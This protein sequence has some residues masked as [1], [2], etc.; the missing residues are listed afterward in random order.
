MFDNDISSLAIQYK[1][2]LTDPSSANYDTKVN[3]VGSNINGKINSDYV[4]TS[5]LINT[6]TGLFIEDVY[7]EFSVAGV[8]APA[9]LVSDQP[10]IR[11]N[12]FNNDF[13]GSDIDYFSSIKNDIRS[14]VL[15]D[16]GSNIG[17]DFNG[18]HN[19]TR[20]LGVV[21][22]IHPLQNDEEDIQSRI[23]PIKENN[24]IYNQN[25]NDLDDIIADVDDEIIDPEELLDD[26]DR[27]NFEDLLG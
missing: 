13:D 9:T 15:F 17:F 12:K 24:D 11:T 8:A 23:N 4:D 18:L 22:M 27:D 21:D 26:P 6:E 1:P 5:P 14:N 19:A 10:T 16:D 25:L 7:N 20:E 2:D 3:T